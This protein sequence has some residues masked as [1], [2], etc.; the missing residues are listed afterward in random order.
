MNDSNRIP[1]LRLCKPPVK[2]TPRDERPVRE[3]AGFDV[4][5][6]L[7]EVRHLRA[8]I[9]R[10]T[11]PSWIMA[12]ECLNCGWWWYGSG[13]GLDPRERP[14]RRDV[15]GCETRHLKVYAVID[16][17]WDTPPTKAMW[18]AGL[19]RPHARR[20]KNR[21]IGIDAAMPVAENRTGTR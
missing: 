12:V 18:T 17:I 10:F 19:K 20:I 15:G 1:H 7:V 13:Y 3:L 5:D 2:P 21:A 4:S 6:R 9:E 11:N 14:A 8:V 16:H